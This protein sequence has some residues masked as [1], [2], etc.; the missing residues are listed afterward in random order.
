MVQ[1]QP[2]RPEITAIVLA[3]GRATRMGGVDKGLVNLAGEPMVAHVLRALLPQ[4][5][6]VLINANRSLGEYAS[7]GWPV[8]PDLETGFLG[9]L[10]GLAAGLRAASTPLA[11]TVPC[12]SPLL[13]PDL[14][15][16]LYSALEREDADLSV[17]HDGERLQ[18]VFALVKRTLLG[19]LTAYLEGGGRKIDRWFEQQR[20]VRVDFSDRLETFVNVN[21]PQERAALEAR[22]VEYV[23]G[24]GVVRRPR[25]TE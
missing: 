9:P 14:V 6:R 4:V 7:F 8:V 2:D 11:L 23:G 22:L 20:V 19:S 10:A 3:G 17:P 13:A 12:D 5:D 21:D 16:R 18:P 24:I 1:L 25:E 15:A